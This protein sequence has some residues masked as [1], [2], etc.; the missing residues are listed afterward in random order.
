VEERDPDVARRDLLE[1]P[2]QALHLVGRLRVDATQRRL[3]E[4]GKRRVREASDES[5]HAGDPD[6]GPVQVDRRRLPVEDTDAGFAECGDELV[7]AIPVPVVI[8]E[9]G[10]DRH[11]DLTDCLDERSRL[12]GLAVQRQIACE[13]DQVSLAAGVGEDSGEALVSRPSR[14]DVSGCRDLDHNWTVPPNGPRG[15]HAPWQI[16]TSSWKR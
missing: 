2:G 13:Q 1:P 4:V 10:E 3:A 5:L 16:S 12:A 6:G 15:N 11:V 9:D 14:V 7:A 8:P